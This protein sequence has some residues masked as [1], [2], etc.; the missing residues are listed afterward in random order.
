M[1]VVVVV[2]VVM[3]VVVVVVP[4]AAAAAALASS[5]TS[6]SSSSSLPTFG[7]QIWHLGLATIGSSSAHWNAA[8]KSGELL[9]TARTRT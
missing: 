1:V 5:L 7:Y 6:L 3:V 8:W 2:M 9:M 4:A